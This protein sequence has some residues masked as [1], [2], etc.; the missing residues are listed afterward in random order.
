M[1]FASAVPV[2]VTGDALRQAGVANLAY[3]LGRGVKVAL[4]FGDR[5]Y[6]C[7]WTGG[8]ATAKATPWS[9]QGDF[10]AAGYQEL[11]NLPAGTAHGGVVKQAGLLSFT[12][13]FDVGHSVSSYA[14]DTAF[15]I[16]NRTLFGLDVATGTL[17]ATNNYYRTT[18]PTDSF[19][20]RNTLPEG[21]PLTDTCMV[22]GQFLPVNPWDKLLGSS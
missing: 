9:S 11:Q 7:P 10:V 5:D 15:T 17:P 22:A 18:G 2:N 13:I 19:G 14:P 1:G 21:A 4:L 20:W 3:L 12:R 6:R 16:F 8:E